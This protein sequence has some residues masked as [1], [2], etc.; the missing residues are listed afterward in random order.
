MRIVQRGLVLLGDRVE[1][2]RRGDPVER[3]GEGL[4]QAGRSSIGIA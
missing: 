4:Q 1:P 3:D 2:V